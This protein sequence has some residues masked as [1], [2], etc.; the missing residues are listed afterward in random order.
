[1]DHGLDWTF[2]AHRFMP[3]GQSWT[4]GGDC[5]R[6]PP[7]EPKMWFS[8]VN[9]VSLWQ[10]L[11]RIRSPDGSTVALTPR[12]RYCVSRALTSFVSS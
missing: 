9:S 7:G 8:S 5:P 4:L 11:C 1:M 10:P 3:A 6:V 12:G 2:H